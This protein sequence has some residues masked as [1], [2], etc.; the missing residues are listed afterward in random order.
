MGSS[1]CLGGVLGGRFAGDLVV[2]HLGVVVLESALSCTTLDGLTT[3]PFEV[4]LVSG[5]DWNED[6]V[7]L[8]V[9]EELAHGLD[10]VLSTIVIGH[11]YDT[12]LT[13]F[14]D[15]MAVL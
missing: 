1:S 4:V 12:V 14:D 7:E 13:I 11:H 5:R 15:L 3:D 2:G 6:E 9:V 10:K 8:L